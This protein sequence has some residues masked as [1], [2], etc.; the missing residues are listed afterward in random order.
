MR[1]DGAER[2]LR[3]R[4]IEFASLLGGCISQFI[5][6]QHTV[7]RNPLYNESAIDVTDL[8]NQV[9]NVVIA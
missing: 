3:K 6:I 9:L 4:F 7:A 1:L 8:A 2:R 5:P